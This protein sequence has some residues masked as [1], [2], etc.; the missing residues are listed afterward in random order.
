MPDENRFEEELE[1]AYEA[2]SNI[3]RDNIFRGGSQRRTDVT[4]R[5]FW[6]IVDRY[7][8]PELE[9]M[10]TYLERNYRNMNP[11]DLVEYHIK[12]LSYF[13]RIEHLNIQGTQ[14]FDIKELRAISGLYQRR[15]EQQRLESK[16]D[17]QKEEINAFKEIRT[18]VNNLFLIL[19]EHL[20]N[21]KFS[22]VNPWE[23][24]N[25]LGNSDIKLEAYKSFLKYV[26]N[27]INPNEFLPLNSNIESQIT[28]L[29]LTKTFYGENKSSG[30]A[31]TYLDS[32]PLEQKVMAYVTY[33]YFLGHFDQK[34]EQTDAEIKSIKDSLVSVRLNN[35]E[36]NRLHLFEQ[37]K[38]FKYSPSAYFAAYTNSIWALIN[39]FLIDLHKKGIKVEVKVNI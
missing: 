7:S 1:S 22:L 20:Y 12:I 9:D 27:K 36:Y 33:T 23:R 26:S 13:E 24:D 16:L 3:K 29:Q 28:S 34:I 17:G 19:H 32:I 21:D 10:I 5:T 14:K 31:K 15:E 2:F 39:N 30:E 6:D 25:L 38:H 18:R 11:K 4:G 35:S 37:G 8:H